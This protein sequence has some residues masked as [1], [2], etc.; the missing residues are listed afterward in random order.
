MRGLKAVRKM[1][2]RRASLQQDERLPIGL[3]EVCSSIPYT[4]LVFVG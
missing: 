3:W 4:K 1:T 2:E